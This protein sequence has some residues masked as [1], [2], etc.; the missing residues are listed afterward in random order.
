MEKKSVSLFHSPS[1]IFL[2]VLLT[3][4]IAGA[5]ITFVWPELN[6]AIYGL[7]FIFLAIKYVLRSMTASYFW[8]VHR[9]LAEVLHPVAMRAREDGLVLRPT[10]ND[11]AVS[12]FLCMLNVPLLLVVA[13]NFVSNVYFPSTMVTDTL[14]APTI[15]FWLSTFLYVPCFY[16]ARHVMLKR[17]VRAS[18][19]AK[20]TPVR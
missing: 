4:M 12:R 1:H 8:K 2:D 11:A 13:A 9:Y 7:S 16:I 6:G 17:L 3:Y 20:A 5:A 14:R 10:I 15:V 19:V 18:W